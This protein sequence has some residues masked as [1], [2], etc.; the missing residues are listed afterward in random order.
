MSKIIDIFWRGARNS[1]P[2]WWWVA[3][4]TCTTLG[5]KR[6]ESMKLILTIVSVLAML[7][8]AW[9]VAQGTG[10]APIGFMA[11]NMTWAYRGAALFVVALIA[12]IFA[13]RQ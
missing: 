1:A 11:N 6:E 9:W 3:A 12:F 13:R 4:P 10:L 2:F 5:Q 7:L 8:G